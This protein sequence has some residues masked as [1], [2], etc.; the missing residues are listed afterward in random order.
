MKQS[1]VA[2]SALA[3]LVSSFL[4]T[5]FQ[6]GSTEMTSAKLY[7]QRSDWQN[8]EK[9]LAKEVEKNPKNFEAW[10]FLGYSRL[11]LKN[12]QDAVHCLD[13][14]M[15]PGSE[16]VTKAKDAR[17]FAWQATLNDGVNKYNASISVSKDSATLLR[18]KAINLYKLAIAFDADSSVTYHRMAIAYLA[19]GNYTEE[20]AALRQALERKKDM[21]FYRLIVNAYAQMADD[22]EANKNKEESLKNYN[23]AL[24]ALKESRDL[25]PDNQE[26]LKTMID[27]YIRI[28]RA[29]EAKPIMQVA[30][31]KDPSNKIYLYDL[32]V[33]LMQGDSLDEAIAYFEKAL[34]IDE[35]YEEALRNCALAYMKVGQKLKDAVAAS[36]DAKNKDKNV[37]KSYEAPFKHS[38]K[39]LEKLTIIKPADPNL[40]DALATAYGNAGMYKEAKKSIEKADSLRGK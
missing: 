30:L 3:I 22:A 5:G 11:Q 4:F 16:F 19:N 13:Q 36:A 10:Y 40:W 21:E 14:A 15:Q 1:I 38:V 32:G 24:A 7:I 17:H 37:D 25:D 9:S 28:G 27:L 34:A 26:L 20:I 35:N 18:Q 39:L 31:Q 33:L 23:L 12:Y 29:P 2:V 6:C 8:A